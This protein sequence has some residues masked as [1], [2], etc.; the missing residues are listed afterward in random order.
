[1]LTWVEEE[2][3]S[4]Y[5]SVCT[6]HWAVPTVLEGAEQKEEDDREEELE[7]AEDQLGAVLWN[8]NGAAL[9]WLHDHILVSLP[10]LKGQRIVELGAGVGCL[11]IA[12]AMGGAT[13]C[14]TDL[15]ELLPLIR[16]NIEL[17]RRRVRERSGGVGHCEALEWRWGPGESINIR[18]RLKKLGATPG[19]R[20][21]KDKSPSEDAALASAVVE[22][23]SALRQPSI[24]M[25]G[26][27]SVF[28]S[29]TSID[30][31]DEDG[32]GR[33][34]R[35]K[36]IS[37]KQEAL[38]E[39][40]I[41]VHMVILCD[42]LYGNPKDWPSLLYTLSEIL[43][44]NPSECRV[45]NFCEQRV[46]DVEGPFLKLLDAENAAGTLSGSSGC[47][48]PYDAEFVAQ[49]LIDRCRGGNPAS[50]G[51]HEGQT[52]GNVDLE[53]LNQAILAEVTREK[54]GGVYLWSFSTRTLGTEEG[55]GGRSDLDMIIRVT[56]ISWKQKAT[57]QR[58]NEVDKRRRRECL[59]ENAA[60]PSAA[61]PKKLRREIND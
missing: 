9:R 2:V 36:G 5:G 13:V 40:G 54:R 33:R 28:A 1:M 10:S 16:Y 45:V 23:L 48:A 46:T 41:P 11:G 30:A 43:E 47:D 19:K 24:A 17:N 53:Q 50:V 6:R 15:K 49:T 42:A 58:S 52:A 3:E 56:E 35:V 38:V 14:I 44:T 39:A 18:K 4:P 27:Q 31:E 37:A 8:S 34:K 7:E 61:M 59:D 21:D 25:R 32:G 57:I 12:L 51:R 29:H 26:C 55:G 20:S 22:A 60:P